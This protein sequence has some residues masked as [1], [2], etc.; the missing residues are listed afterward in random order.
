[1][2][3]IRITSACGTGTKDYGLAPQHEGQT[4]NLTC[5]SLQSECAFCKSSF[6][7]PIKTGFI[8][9]PVSSRSFLVNDFQMGIHAN[10]FCKDVKYA[11][12]VPGLIFC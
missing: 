6:K 2:V 11:R 1:M 3:Q 4:N 8:V 10:V 5:V 12:P 9:C 7:W